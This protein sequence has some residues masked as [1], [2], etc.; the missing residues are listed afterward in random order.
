MS[1]YMAILPPGSNTTGMS[2]QMKQGKIMINEEREIGIE[3][4]LRSWRELFLAAKL[5]FPRGRSPRG[6]NYRGEAGS[7]RNI[8][9]NRQFLFYRN[10]VKRI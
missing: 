3:I 2:R 4:S 1:R 8:T 6:K 9:P 5:P 10:Q 7:L